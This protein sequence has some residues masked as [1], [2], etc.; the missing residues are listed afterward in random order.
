MRWR[1]SNTLNKTAKLTEGYFGDK[2]VNFQKF[3]DLRNDGRIVW[4]SGSDVRK[5][6]RIVCFNGMYYQGILDI[7][8]IEY[9]HG[10]P[11]AWGTMENTDKKY[12][13]DISAGTDVIVDDSVKESDFAY[14]T[15]VFSIKVELDGEAGNARLELPDY[16]TA[17]EVKK[18]ISVTVKEMK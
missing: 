9:E 16:F 2:K 15:K 18:S 10:A 7:E 4:R 13:T 8:K 14:N 1:E 12:G 3:A 6:D 11:N 17:E 5:G